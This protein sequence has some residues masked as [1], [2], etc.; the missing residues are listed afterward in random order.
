MLSAK[1]N[2]AG[3][4][5]L[6][7]LNFLTLINPESPCFNEAKQTISTTEKK[8]DNIERQQWDLLRLKVKTEY[9]LT[10]LYILAAR[11]ISVAYSRQYP[12]A[13]YGLYNFLN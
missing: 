6:T 1:A 4:Q 9:E 12:N 2:I 3:N 7:G 8:L 13:Y 11:D 10:R 5:Y